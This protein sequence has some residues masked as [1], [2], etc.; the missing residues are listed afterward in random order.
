MKR[1]EF[2]K[3]LG[4]I[5]LFSI[6]SFFGLALCM[7]ERESARER[8][9][10]RKRKQ[11]LDY[12]TQC[13][14]INV[15]II[16]SFELLSTALINIRPVIIYLICMPASVS[17]C[18]PLCL[19]T[20]ILHLLQQTAWYFGCPIMAAQSRNSGLGWLTLTKNTFCCLF[21]WAAID[22]TAECIADP[23]VLG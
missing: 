14:N 12:C 16:Y 18:A 1:I 13:S 8:K 10:E 21:D 17:E 6:N 9:R 4:Y 22:S 20:A 2:R 23:G 19:S 15:M 11:K 5:Y 3:W 7:W